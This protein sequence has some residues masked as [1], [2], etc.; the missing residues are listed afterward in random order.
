MIDK[1]C[2]CKWLVE[3][4]IIKISWRGFYGN[5]N[6]KKNQDG[7]FFLFYLKN[8]AINFDSDCNNKFKDEIIDDFIMK[9]LKV[10]VAEDN[11][12]DMFEESIEKD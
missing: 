5:I 7:L 11:S 4:A 12:N 2:T 9:L 3:G 8:S 10:E 1:D 6:W